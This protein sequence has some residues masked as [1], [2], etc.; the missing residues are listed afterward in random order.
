MNITEAEKTLIRFI[1]DIDIHELIIIRK[2]GPKGVSVENTDTKQHMMLK[3]M[4]S[5]KD[6]RSQRSFEAW[7][8]A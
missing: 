2:T 6:D 3:M 8:K 7:P 5:W 4:N 1:R